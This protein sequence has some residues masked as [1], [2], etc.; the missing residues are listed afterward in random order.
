MV[1]G[2]HVDN[3]A[4]GERLVLAIHDETLDSEAFHEVGFALSVVIDH[5]VDLDLVEFAQVFDGSG[6][7]LLG[8]GDDLE[9]A[10]VAQEH[11]LVELGAR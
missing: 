3:A 4:R 5:G 6:V 10:V 2:E 1:G 9:H 11:K 8:N 7:E